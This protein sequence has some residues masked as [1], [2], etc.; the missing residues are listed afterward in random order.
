MFPNPQDAL[1]LPPRPS[2]QQY[3]KLAKDL[4]K[5]CD[6]A[7]A[8]IAAWA[9]R[10]MAGL[11]AG[12]RVPAAAPAT[13]SGADSR[14]IG[15][16]ASHVAVVRLLLERGAR[17][18]MRSRYGDIVEAAIWRAAHGG[19]PDRSAEIIEALIAAGGKRPDHYLPGTRYSR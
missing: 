16:G 17:P 19:N 14:A 11:L 3:R 1:P 2:L 7:A 4:V 10:W 5:A 8:A 9:D 12:R 15:A 6:S 13:A 18:G